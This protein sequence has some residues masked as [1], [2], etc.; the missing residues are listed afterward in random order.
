MKHER[1]QQSR[2]FTLWEN[3]NRVE[4]AI[5]RLSREIEEIDNFFYQYKDEDRLLRAGM[6]ERKRDDMVRSIVLQLHTAIEDLLNGFISFQITGATRRHRSQSARAL[7][8]ILLGGGSMGFEMKLNL[9]LALRLI[10]SKTK[11][12]LTILNGLRNK[13]SHN[14]VL[15]VPVRYGKRPAQRKPP[16]LLFEGRDLHGVAALK[17]FVKE[18]SGIYLKLFLK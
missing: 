1:L 6:L 17:D 4:A 8:K 2:I 16:L 5:K 3:P 10:S 13:C 7:R 15:N 9:A 14:W 11:H 18:Y 12:R